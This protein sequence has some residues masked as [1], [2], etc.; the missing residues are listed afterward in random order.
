ML[1]PKYPTICGSRTDASSNYRSTSGAASTDYGQI[2]TGF[3]IY[4]FKALSRRHF[5][6][7]GLLVVDLHR[8][9]VLFHCSLSVAACFA[10]LPLFVAAVLTL[11]AG[12]FGYA[13][14]TVESI[15]GI[16]L[17]C[18]S[19]P[20]WQRLRRVGR[21]VGYTVYQSRPVLLFRPFVAVFICSACSFQ[22]SLHRKRYT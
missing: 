18:L 20:R 13:Y 17:N 15:L 7:V 6:V 19:S 22:V 1:K 11:A 16:R 9:P 3:I 10:R 8:W 5:G 12:I 2:R 21:Y 14:S 4:S